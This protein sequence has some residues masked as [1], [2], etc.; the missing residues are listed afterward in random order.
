MRSNSL[1]NVFHS[2]TFTKKP[3]SLR[4]TPLKADDILTDRLG[5]IDLNYQDTQKV[6]RDLLEHHTSSLGT[7]NE[8]MSEEAL[9]DS[10]AFTDVP[11]KGRSSLS[12]LNSSQLQ[13]LEPLQEGEEEEEGEAPP[14][15]KDDPL[16]S[17]TSRL[18]P[19]KK[20]RP[21]HP[22]LL[23]TK[24]ALSMPNIYGGGSKDKDLLTD[25]KG[26]CDLEYSDMKK[27]V[28]EV[29]HHDTMSPKNN[30]TTATRSSTRS[31]INEITG[32]STDFA[33]PEEEEVEDRKEETTPSTTATIEEEETEAQRESTSVT[34]PKK[35]GFFQKLKARASKKKTL[36][37]P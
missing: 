37:N 8:R 24:G 26:I 18:F 29:L 12:D 13:S 30:P 21:N 3:S 27:I 15:P 25:H 11:K 1:P 35:K 17:P 4:Q 14:L 33:I 32:D 22:A 7:L 36:G 31:S 34:K 9:D 28:Q 2:S 16:L 6:V 23:H 5:M 19:K 10:H 20:K